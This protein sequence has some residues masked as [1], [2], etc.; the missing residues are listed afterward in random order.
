M[1][2]DQWTTPISINYNYSKQA[3]DTKEWERI[4]ARRIKIGDPRDYLGL[5]KDRKK[6]FW[7]TDE[8]V[9][10]VNGHVN[11]FDANFR[12]NFFVKKV[13]AILRRN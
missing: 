3:R 9:F 1:N 2:N 5:A 8:N 12:A 11:K 4:P 7:T 13:P 6:N 10:I